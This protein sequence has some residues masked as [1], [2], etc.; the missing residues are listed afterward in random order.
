MKRRRKKMRRESK[1]GEHK[2]S[3]GVIYK[4]CA[5]THSCC[6][7]PTHSLEIGT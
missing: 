1:Q 2:V 4:T 6:D 7:N 3:A 5:H